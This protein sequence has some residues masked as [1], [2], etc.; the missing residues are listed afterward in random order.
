MTLEVEGYKFYTVLEIANKL[1]LSQNTIRKYIKQGKMQGKK[2]GSKLYISQDS[3]T[4][5]LTDIPIMPVTF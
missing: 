3:L 5:Y 1:L 2:I 4:E